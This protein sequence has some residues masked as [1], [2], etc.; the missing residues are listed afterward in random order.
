MPIVTTPKRIPILTYHALH[1]PGWDYASN[2]HVALER[3][4]AEIK[5]V[6][7]RV[8]SLQRIAQAVI[9]GAVEELAR[10]RLVGISF[11]DGTDHD[12]LDFSHP[13]Y[14]HLKSMARVLREGGA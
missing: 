12:Y 4:L 14:G 13:G 1:A 10:H 5:S 7:F 2:D 8:V 11:D 9:A 6:G 3:D